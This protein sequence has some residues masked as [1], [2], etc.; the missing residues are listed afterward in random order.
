MG[1]ME[2]RDEVGTPRSPFSGEGGRRAT[3][4]GAGG[5]VSPTFAR[6]AD[7]FDT[8]EAQRVLEEAASTGGATAVVSLSRAWLRVMTGRAVT[9]EAATPP[10]P[11]VPA[12][13]LMEPSPGHGPSLFSGGGLGS[14]IFGATAG[15]DSLGR[16][17][18]PGLSGVHAPLADGTAE[19][20]RVSL[21]PGG[22]GQGQPLYSAL[23]LGGTAPGGTAPGGTADRE[24]SPRDSRHE[25]PPPEPLRDATAPATAPAGGDGGASV[26][27]GP[28]RGAR[29]EP[30]GGRRST[31][32]S[33]SSSSESDSD[34]RLNAESELRDELA[35][36]RNEM[37]ELRQREAARDYAGQAEA[38]RR[39]AARDA[40]TS[41]TE[42][43]GRNPDS[44]AGT[45]PIR[46]R[47][48]Q[49]LILEERRRRE[50]AH[51]EADG[52]AAR[53]REAA[54]ATPTPRAG[55][56]ERIH[57]A[58]SGGGVVS[59][60]RA[61]FDSTTFRPAARSRTAASPMT[62][63]DPTDAVETRAPEGAGGGGGRGGGEPG[64]FGH[65]GSHF[66]PQ[67]SVGTPSIDFVR[68]FSRVVKLRTPDEFEG[69]A[70]FDTDP[71]V[72]HKNFDWLLSALAYAMR[73]A[74]QMR[75]GS[76]PDWSA[77]LLI[78]S[79]FTGEAE[80][81]YLTS[82]RRWL[83]TSA[84]GGSFLLAAEAPGDV[85][86]DLRA[87]E[88]A[89]V[90]HWT[91][92]RFPQLVRK[93]FN[94]LAIA[95]GKLPTIRAFANK[96][97]TLLSKLTVLGIA[98]DAEQLAGRLEEALSNA[99]GLLMF[100]RT[101]E[102]KLV[103]AD[104]TSRR[105]RGDKCYEGIVE[106]LRQYLL[107][108]PT[109][110]PKP[111]GA[112][113]TAIE[114]GEMFVEDDDDVVPSGDADG[115]PPYEWFES[116]FEASLAVAADVGRLETWADTLSKSGDAAFLSDLA[117]MTDERRQQQECFNCHKTGHIGTDCP[118]PETEWYRDFRRKFEARRAER[119]RTRQ[120][121]RAPGGGGRGISAGR[122]GGK[123]WPPVPG[124]P[125]NGSGRGRGGA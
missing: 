80:A 66:L 88:K 102:V 50:A 22:A 10:T 43:E 1:D 120:Q 37:A 2:W 5:G 38:R 94:Q 105:V 114:T 21:R 86:N 107:V 108:A 83:S 61:H 71:M 98:F 17:A 29:T 90:Q 31:V 63:A 39:E 65:G 92:A 27:D 57:G 56:H 51:V 26:G 118:E 18:P 67:M 49:D 59:R 74:A 125:P 109:R 3:T 96:F 72:G 11:P 32:P 60:D 103:N 48:P 12:S 14:P 75:V 7:I 81:W 87:F 121:S 112:Q 93:E 13:G 116:Q 35:A 33:S 58:D 68:N 73:V 4:V 111:L 30:R 84:A 82:V 15:A 106:G 85:V 54:Q 19:R 101:H 95:D 76:L 62:P 41:R 115:E 53:R 78:T 46:D 124:R 110:P 70:S 40:Q 100:I 36:L 117:V 23:L 8:P 16:I 6:S 104:G 123:A 34:D 69:D 113:L 119:D 45:D 89:F 97:D 91:P 47:D 77:I 79:L 122:G 44:R 99:P 20:P 64:A 42:S 52:N 24:Q 55:A 25:T 28:P 9:P